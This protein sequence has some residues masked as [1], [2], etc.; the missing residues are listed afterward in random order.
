MM[1]SVGACPSGGGHAAEVVAPGAAVVGVGATEEH[2]HAHRESAKANTNNTKRMSRRPAHLFSFQ[3][4][5]LF[6]LFAYFQLT[7][8]N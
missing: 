5:S 4:A 1:R 2:R 6:N 8:T 3:R 7:D